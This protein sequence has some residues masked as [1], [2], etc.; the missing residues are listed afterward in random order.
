MVFCPECL[1]SAREPLKDFEVVKSIETSW[2]GLG[3]GTGSR[4]GREKPFILAAFSSKMIINHLAGRVIK[5]HLEMDPAEGNLV[6]VQY[7]RWSV[8]RSFWKRATI[9][10]AVRRQKEGDYNTRQ[11][12]IQKG[13]QF[14]KTRSKVRAEILYESD[15]R[16]VPP[17]ENMEG[18]NS[19]Q[20]EGRFWLIPT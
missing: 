2:K 15:C 5:E 8:S 9:I 7:T 19:W 10:W 20:Y 11:V 18:D 12:A 6:V 3:E 17:G 16:G 13:P 1:H 14:Q 4:T